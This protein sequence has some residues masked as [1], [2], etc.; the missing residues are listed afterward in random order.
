MLRRRAPEG[1]GDLGGGDVQQSCSRARR[2]RRRPGRCGPAALKGSGRAGRSRTARRRRGPRCSRTHSVACGRVATVTNRG[3][4][5]AEARRAPA[6]AHGGWCDP[7]SRGRWRPRRPRPRTPAFSSLCTGPSSTIPGVTTTATRRLPPRGAEGR[8]CGARARGVG[9]V[10]VVEHDDTAG[11]EC[12]LQP[13]R[14]T[15]QCRQAAGPRHRRGRRAR[16]ATATAAAT[17]P[18]RPSTCTPRRDL[19]P[20]DTHRGSALVARRRTRL[21]RCR[22]PRRATPAPRVVHASRPAPPGARRRPRAP[23][24]ARPRGSRPWP[25]ATRSSEPKRSRCTGPMAVITATSGRTHEH[26]SAISPRP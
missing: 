2:M 22:A 3:P 24:T 14:G 16:S 19:G 26:S 13:V 23:H 25:R 15:G 4:G 18:G 1:D 9:V 5:P 21:R 10:G 7:R 6:A 11:A 12:L 8:Q 17:L 20:A